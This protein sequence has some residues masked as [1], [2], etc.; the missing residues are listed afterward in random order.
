MSCVVVIVFALR[1]LA[2][3]AAASIGSSQDQP[4]PRQIYDQPITN[5]LRLQ[6]SVIDTDK[7]RNVCCST[8]ARIRIVDRDS[9]ASVEIATISEEYETAFAVERA[10]DRALILARSS[11]DYGFDQGRI[12]LFFDASAKRLLKRIDFDSAHDITFADDAEA[13]R[14]LGVTSNVVLQLRQRGVLSAQPAERSLPAAF[15]RRP[16]PQS[17][18][19]KFAHARPGRVQ[20]GYD[21]AGTTIKERI[22]A[23]QREG[24]RL[25]FGKVFYDGEGTS[26]VGAI[27]SLS[28]AGVYAFLRIPELFDWSVQGLLVEPDAIWAGRVSHGE[29]ADHSGGMLRYDRKARRVHLYDVPDVI[30]SIVHVDEAVFVGTGHGLYVIKNGTKMRYRAEPDMAGGF[31]VMAEDVTGGPG[32]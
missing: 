11:P 14:V 13:A 6:V 5:S 25:W 19:Q 30:H 18:Y 31:I 29:G 32:R 17:T 27:G 7:A 1:G 10:D 9:D 4:R 23:H 3:L 8:V 20:D 2:L 28:P 24:D 16:L 12:K 21:R 15:K 26:G 22:G